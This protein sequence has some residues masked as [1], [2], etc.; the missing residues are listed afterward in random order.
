MILRFRCPSCWKQME[1]ERP[2]TRLEMECPNCQSRLKYFAPL[3]KV[4]AEL[5]S[6]IIASVISGIFGILLLTGMSSVFDISALRA[7][8]INA[9]AQ[10]I[11]SEIVQR[12]GRKGIL[13]SYSTSH[14]EF[15]GGTYSISRSLSVNSTIGVVYLPENPKVFMIGR[16]EDSFSTLYFENIGILWSILGVFGVSAIAFGGVVL[17]NSYACFSKERKGTLYRAA[18]VEAGIFSM[19][20]EWL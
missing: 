17:F 14:I 7:H 16:Q 20:V 3:I 4:Q 15:A 18:D 12:R 8:G 13:K 6:G 9:Q 1:L 5:K 10:V 11:D 2:K 19:P